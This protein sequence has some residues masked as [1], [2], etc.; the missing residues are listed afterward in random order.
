MYSWDADHVLGMN[1]M[2]GSVKSNPQ[3][4]ARPPKRRMRTKRETA[5]DYC[6]LKKI[7]CNRATPDACANCLDR[8]QSC[9]TAGPLPQDRQGQSAVNIP[10]ASNASLI[11]SRELQVTTAQKTPATLE[12][13]T[14][15]AAVFE[16]TEDLPNTD[17]SALHVAGTQPQPTKE[18]FLN[19][20]TQA[21]GVHTERSEGYASLALATDESHTSPQTEAQQNWRFL[22]TTSHQTSTVYPYDNGSVQGVSD[23]TRITRADQALSSQVV[24]SYEDDG[25][26]SNESTNWEYH[27]PRSC[28]SLCSQSGIEWVE[29][30]TGRSGFRRLAQSFTA[31]ITR[32]LILSSGISTKRVPDLDQD[33]AWKYTSAYFQHALDASMGVVHQTTFE[34]QLNAYLD[35]VSNDLDTAWHALRNAIYASG[36]RIYLSETRSFYEANRVA[37]T[38]FE[39]ALALYT[40]TLLFKTSLTSV[41]ALTA[42]YSQNFG[43][44]CLEYMLCNNALALAVGKGLHRR[45]TPGW[46]LTTN[47]CSHRSCLFWALYCLEKQI[48]KQSGRPSIINDDEV[49]CELPETPSSNMSFSMTYLTALVKLARFASIVNRRLS[50]VRVLRIGAH[51]LVKLV[52]ELDEQ[53]NILKLDLEPAIFLG[54]P[55]NPNR[56][57]PGISLQQA[58]YLYCFYY[59]TVLDI[60]N[61]LIYPWSKTL[62]GL[63][64]DRLLRT[65]VNRS[66]EMVTRTCYTA[67]LTLHYVHIDAATPVPLSFFTPIYV[68]TNLFICILQNPS[69]NRVP[70][71]LSL[72]DLGAAFF[73]R[74]HVASNSEVPMKFAKEL[75]ALARD[76]V[77]KFSSTSSL[78]AI[79]MDNAA[80]FL[81]HAVAGVEDSYHYSQLFSFP[82]LSMNATDEHF[83]VII[84]FYNQVLNED[85]DLCQAAQK[86][87][88]AGIFTNGELHPEKE[89]VSIDASQYRVN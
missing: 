69:H 10:G 3:A 48:E 41:Q 71:A 78:S 5:C 74:L 6:K 77:Q 67:M 75:T 89:I 13:L 42:Y 81:E 17:D 72:M 82:D 70:L 35:G 63:T 84:S 16:H 4:E 11:S 39:N 44:P 34:S 76:T 58:V 9:T 8:R 23:D 54:K 27:G 45:P 7:R 14:L 86:N 73:T 49:T 60:H 55:L 68:L 12:S 64:P 65:Q 47:E 87:L 59:T 43:S 83:A 18:S 57:G 66:I 24:E 31:D 53:L 1:T 22:N 40:E 30:R 52:T 26:S 50:S 21:Y 32:R 20:P 2:Q 28:L 29:T 36:C 88:N 33:T 51:A 19:Y 85:K 37:W 46:N 79:E 56:L 25:I 62:L 61:T 80:D 15:D 38:Y